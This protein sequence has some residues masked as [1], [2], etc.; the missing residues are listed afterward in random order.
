MTECERKWSKRMDG[1]LY[2]IGLIAVVLAV[3]TLIA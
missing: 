2:L 1:F 3:F